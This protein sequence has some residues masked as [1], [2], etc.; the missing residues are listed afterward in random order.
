M[1]APD[2][3][4]TQVKIP[5]FEGGVITGNSLHG[6]KEEIMTD[7]EMDQAKTDVFADRML[8]ILNDGALALMTSIGHRT[9]LFDV[10]SNL[11][12]ASKMAAVSRIQP[13]VVSTK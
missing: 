8:N 2:S 11:P 1:K 9:G 5:I 4:K 3:C 7:I 12:P 10:M 6:P 13:L